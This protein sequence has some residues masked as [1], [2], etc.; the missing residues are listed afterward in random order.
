MCIS[1]ERLVKFCAMKV[2]SYQV[3]EASERGKRKANESDRRRR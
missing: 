3:P 1:P 2:R